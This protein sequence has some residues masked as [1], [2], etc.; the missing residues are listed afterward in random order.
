MSLTVDPMAD[1]EPRRRY[2]RA[3]A[4]TIGWILLAVGVYV[5]G[6]VSRERAVIFGLLI[7]FIGSL[8]VLRQGYL[9]M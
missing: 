5:T 7:W 9:A 6:K 1:P 8:P 3:L 2:R 4:S